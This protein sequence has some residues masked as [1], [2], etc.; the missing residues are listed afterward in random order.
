MKTDHVIKIN[1]LGG[2]F[3][4]LKLQSIVEIAHK[5]GVKNINFGPR[6]EI[7]F[8]VHKELLSDFVDAM[9]LQ[10]MDYEVDQNLFPNIVSSY[11]AEGIFSSDYWLSEGIY[12]DIFDQFDYVPK[13]KINICDND[14]TLVP[15]F[16][17]ELNFIA[18]RTYQYWFLY[19]NLKEQDEI[20]RWNMLIYSTD[21]P[22][23]CR[24][25]EELYIN[26]KIADIATI[27]DLV[28]ENTKFLFI[29]IDKELELPRFVFPYY[30]GMSG[31]GDKFWLGVYRRDYMFPISFIH[32][33]C[34]LCINSNIGQLCTTTWRT[35]MIKGISQKDRI[36]WEKLLGKHGINLRHS[37][38][39]LNWVVDDI[40]SSEL[41]LK[42]Y[43]IAQLDERDM[44]TYGL[45]FGVKLQS[46]QYIPASV[47]IEEIPFIHRGDLKL[48][49][50][51]DIYYTEN[52]NPNSP[53][54]ILFAKNI[55]KNNLTA[56]ILELCKNYYE[57]LNEIEKGTIF[58]Q[59][60]ANKTLVPNILY[61]CQHCYSV[62][63]E[64]LGDVFAHV[65]PNSSF[66]S[67]P[68]TYTCQVCEAPKSD[69]IQITDLALMA[70]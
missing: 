19:L 27:M 16:T 5:A 12:K 14:Q 9:D 10:K 41:G 45:V 7:Y 49:S 47:I 42:Q 58:E 23:I 38:T 20:F 61:Q 18:S 32:E 11:P 33:L 30:E 70:I 50:T 63:D 40:N 53:N 22:K 48:L 43:I 67:L 24:E 2:I 55:R 26:N 60:K 21:I 1:A 44:R 54:K 57:A 3:T 68:H 13:L 65:Q 51:Y 36:Q 56:R 35:I 6:Q 39:E 28:N 52:F 29:P 46:A 8:N 4:P 66:D 25:I 69:F 59:P 15:F 31:Y 17:G 34:T 37:A 64:R 62:Y